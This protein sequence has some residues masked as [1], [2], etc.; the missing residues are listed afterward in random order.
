MSEGLT[1][2]SLELALLRAAADGRLHRAGLTYRWHPRAH[3]LRA[4]STASITET[5][6]QMHAFGLIEN[7]KGDGPVVITERG[8]ALL[9]ANQGGTL[10]AR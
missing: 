5:G 3:V 8:R 10:R 6:M 2:S 9:A 1:L 7:P 4:L